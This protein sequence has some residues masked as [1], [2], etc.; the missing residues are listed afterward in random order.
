M[1]SLKFPITDFSIIEKLIPHRKPMI[2]VDTVIAFKENKLL[3]GLTV[4][5]ENIFVSKGEFQEAGILE[6]IAQSAALYIGCKNFD[7][8]TV[9]KEGV[10]GAINSANFNT[11]PKIGETIQTDITILHE[12]MGITLFKA[13]CKVEETT[14]CTAEM[15]TMLRNH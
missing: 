11:L 10:V 12:V 1:A 6:H 3:S 7:S 4:E 8:I 13:I 14:I 9:A 15:K 2:M 5:T